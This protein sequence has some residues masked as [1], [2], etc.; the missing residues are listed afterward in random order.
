MSIRPI[1]YQGAI[2]RS[3]QVGKI[4]DQLQQRGQVGQ[5][6]IQEQLKDETNTKRKQVNEA[7]ETDVARFRDGDKEKGQQKHE[8]EKEERKKQQ[9]KVQKSHPYKGQ[10]I[11]FSG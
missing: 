4:Q 6:V 10:F 11:D 7:E 8:K 3:Q 5:E 1:E 2:P 9:K